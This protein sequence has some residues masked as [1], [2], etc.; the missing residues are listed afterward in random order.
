MTI[1]TAPAEL[2][3]QLFHHRCMDSNVRIASLIWLA[4]CGLYQQEPAENFMEFKDAMNLGE[5]TRDQPVIYRIPRLG[6]LLDCKG[7]ITTKDLY[8]VLYGLRGFLAAIETPIHTY[9]SDGKIKSASWSQY[10]R[11]WIYESSQLAVMRQ[12]EIWANKV[13]I[14]DYKASIEAAQKADRAPLLDRIIET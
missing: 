12:A 14:K 2:R 13:Q 1:F 11:A 5:V 7:K 6:E 8:N 4:T 9:Y 3:P 10:R